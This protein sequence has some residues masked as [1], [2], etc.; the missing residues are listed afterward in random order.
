MSIAPSIVE[1]TIQQLQKDEEMYS[2]K[3]TKHLQGFLSAFCQINKLSNLGPEK[4]FL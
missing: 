4:A 3:R 2:K 1:G